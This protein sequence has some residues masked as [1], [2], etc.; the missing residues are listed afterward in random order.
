MTL[1]A[2]DTLLIAQRCKHFFGNGYLE[3]TRLVG[4]IITAEGG[5][6]DALIKAVNKSVGSASFQ[7]A[8]DITCR[9]IAHALIDYAEPTLPGAFV[10]FLAARW[11][12][13]GA[14]NDPTKLNQNWIHDVTVSLS[15]GSRMPSVDS[16]PTS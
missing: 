5:T 13:I 7:D 9:S 11:A 2:A 4:A 15:Q 16:A 3:A 12:P 10:S 8:I 14:A 1:T 6:S